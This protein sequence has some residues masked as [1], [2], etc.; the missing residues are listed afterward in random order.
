VT[1]LNLA[2]LNPADLRLVSHTTSDGVTTRELVLGDVTATLWAP[3]HAEPGTPL[4]LLTHGGGRH[5]HHPSMTGRA[6][7][8]TGA[9]LRAV[10]IDLP[11]HGPRP[12][13]PYDEEQIALLHAARRAGDPIGPIVEPYNAALARRTVPEWR[14][15]L[16]GLL[17][18]PEIGDA[19]VGYWGLTVGTAIGVPLLAAEPLI[20]AAVLGLFWPSTLV[21]TARRVTVPIEFDLQ[22][23]DELIPRE[24][25][26]ALFD[27]FASTEKSLHVNTGKHMDFPR[28]EAES[29]VR[30]F[31]RHLHG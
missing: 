4:V 14:T 31:A 29:A 17:A 5:R 21:E 12:R 7:R 2:R 27:A 13:T 11:G 9:G 22:W 1:D 23:D 25:G 28:F 15:V 18:V 24:D 8:L 26:L 3:E 20:Q 16:A 19:P 6:G 10:A 30:F